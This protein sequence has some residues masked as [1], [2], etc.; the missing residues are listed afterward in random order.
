VVASTLALLARVR[1]QGLGY[2]DHDWSPLSELDV[3]LVARHFGARLRV[4]PLPDEI[5]ELAVPGLAGPHTLR[6]NRHLPA[7]YRRLAMRHGLAHVVAGELE[8]DHDAGPRFLSSFQD[9]FSLEERRADLFALA[10]LIPDREL[11]PAIRAQPSPLGA[12]WWMVGQVQQFATG[13]PKDRLEDRARLR[14][15]LF[16]A[17]EVP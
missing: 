8:G 9:Y 16:F 17:R 4:A 1:G 15:E 10:D 7:P 6:V 5:Q 14:W 3:E 11:V 13:W 12:L 2:A